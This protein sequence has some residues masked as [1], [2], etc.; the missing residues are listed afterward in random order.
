ML[1]RRRIPIARQ[2]MMFLVPAVCLAFFMA[3]AST[4][5]V[6]L[7][8][9]S[10]EVE[11]TRKDILESSAS[12]LVHPLWDCDPATSQGILDVLAHWPSV[13]AAKLEDSCSGVTLVT[14]QVPVSDNV[15]DVIPEHMEITYQD[16]H[17]KLHNVGNLTVYFQNFSLW[18]QAWNQMPGHLVIL[19]ILMGVTLLTVA[20]ANKR[21][22]TG[23]LERFKNVIDE[24]SYDQDLHIATFIDRNDELGDVVKAYNLMIRELHQRFVRQE[25]LSKCS[26]QLLASPASARTG[27]E[28]A[29]E[30]LMQTLDADRVSVFKNI[31]KNGK[32]SMHR[33]FKVSR[34][35]FDEMEAPEQLAYEPI[36]AHW[37][38]RLSDKQIVVECM[39]D[40]FPKEWEV[41]GLQSVL[42]LAAVPIWADSKWWGFCVVE[43]VRKERAWSQSEL[44]FIQTAGDI[45]GAYLQRTEKEEELH[46]EREQFFSILDSIPNIVYVADMDTYEVLF[47]N[48]TASETLGKQIVG[49][50]CYR[51]LQGKDAPCDFCT[52]H[53]IRKQ[54]GAYYWE[55][56]NQKNQHHYY[57]VDQTIRW[58]DGRDVRFEMAMDVTEL[59]IAEQALRESEKY[60]RSAFE[61]ANDGVCLVSPDGFMR[62]VN[63]RM[64]EIFGYSRE[65]LERMS[66]NDIAYSEDKSISPSFIKKSISGNA[67]NFVFE[68]RYIHKNGQLLWGRVSSSMITDHL[69]NPK[70]FISHVQDIT[71]RVMAEKALRESEQRYRNSFEGFESIK[72]IIDPDTC[73]IL[74]ANGAAEDFYGYSRERLKSMFLCDITIASKDEILNLL[75]I[76][77]SQGTAHF[78]LKQQI[79][80]GNSRDVEAY[81]SAMRFN[82]QDLINIS[83]YD[84]TET[85][86]LE[87][88]K[89]DVERIVRH[90]LRS[91]LNA[92]INIPLLL[93]DEKNLTIDQRQML[94]MSSTLAKQ[95]LN[96]IN[97]SLEMYKIE[98]GG[99]EFK[100]L[101][102]D[103]LLAIQDTVKMLDLGFGNAIKIVNIR[104]NI[105]GKSAFSF[106]T[107][108][109]LFHIIMTNLI[110][111]AI[112]A[113]VKLAP[114]FVDLSVAKNCLILEI[115]NSDVIPAEIR[116]CFFEKYRTSGKMGGT[117]LGTYSAAMM[118]KAIGGEIRMQ[119]SDDIGTIITIQ[120]P[121]DRTET[122]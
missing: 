98:T 62:Q 90:D 91:P 103:P 45:I 67:T 51:A 8:T 63:T 119:T 59:K 87:Q 38:D 36:F 58:S 104:D 32:L 31:Q 61:N 112:E 95:M 60:F 80:D 50:P 25:T 33:E 41:M 55:V 101:P 10:R 115:Q 52:N 49:M 5:Y 100:P 53:I 65:E 120:L 46:R 48:S 72:L 108:P 74:D 109:L 37:R 57:I 40:F 85:L 6:Q 111:N 26:R 7:E 20:V 21:I 93:S 86:R 14:G 11:Q 12:S 88:I 89:N 107:D 71:Q 105:D 34:P 39:S 121:F 66:V 118:T 44:T 70:Y 64:S 110:K 84:V 79:S 96:Q 117:G 116:N 4:L 35:D 97:S 83:L 17:E 13:T 1:K 23:P 43:D 42:S 47:A 19:S 9:K 15:K 69:G 2:F 29:L 77:I 56:Q 68:K 102:C 106:K 54:S 27:I 82:G 28:A 122:C 75:N 76:I 113:N 3:G 73:A 18:E 92:L 30:L 114:I 99:Y 22:I 16:E 24:F 94:T 81:T 78:G